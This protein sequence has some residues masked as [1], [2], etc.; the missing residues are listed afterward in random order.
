MLV[1]A[2]KRY[3]GR[4]AARGLGRASLGAALVAATSSRRTVAAGH[5]VSVTPERAEAYKAARRVLHEP[6]PCV[7]CG[8]DF[9][10]NRSDQIVCSTS[11]RWKRKRR[12][13]RE[14]EAAA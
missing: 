2:R 9:T 1:H 5:G 14:R 12:L 3:S 13:K 7:E 11:C 8:E 10:P 4:V 6:R